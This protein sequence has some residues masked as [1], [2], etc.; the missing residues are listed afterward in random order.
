MKGKLLIAFITSVCLV[1]CGGPGARNKWQKNQDFTNRRSIY[2]NEFVQSG[3]MKKDD[4][5]DSI[6]PT[7]IEIQNSLKQ[8]NLFVNR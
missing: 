3:G 5:T 8:G 4:S 1:G 2:Y 7:K 6:N